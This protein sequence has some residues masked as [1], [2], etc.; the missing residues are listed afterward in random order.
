MLGD[1]D[2]KQI[3][4]DLRELECHV[5]LPD[6]WKNDYFDDDG[7]AATRPHERRRFSRRRM[8]TRALLDLEQ[9]LPHVERHENRHIVYT[10]DMSR[11]GFA[12]LHAEQLFPLE[13]AKLSLSN[14]SFVIE[15]ARC[16]RYNE[17]CWMIGARFVTTPGT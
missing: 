5:E 3:A 4:D 8:R 9:S 6:A 1:D 17:K 12:F 15:V 16:R 10:Y 7:I 2:R 11:S 14:T 13:R